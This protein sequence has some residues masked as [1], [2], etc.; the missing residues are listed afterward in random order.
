MCMYVA[1]ITT[2]ILSE[3][4]PLIWQMSGMSC[5]VICIEWQVSYVISLHSNTKITMVK[6][7]Q[8]SSVNSFTFFD[9]VVEHD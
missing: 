3:L 4:T 9:A 5:H 6:S 8:N 7:T 2:P 1:S